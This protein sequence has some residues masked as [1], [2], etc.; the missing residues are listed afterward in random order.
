MSKRG[1]KPKI[2]EENF[3]ILEKKLI[4]EPL[5]IFLHSGIAYG[6]AYATNEIAPESLLKD[7]LEE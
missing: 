6:L 7:R 5:Y 3:P 2:Q 4:D 1:R